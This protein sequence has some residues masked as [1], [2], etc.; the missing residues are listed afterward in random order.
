[1]NATMLR[2]PD[3]ISNN[4]MHAVVYQFDLPLRHDQLNGFRGAFAALAGREHSVFHNHDNNSQSD[5]E[6][7]HRYPLVQYRVHDGNASIYAIGEGAEAIETMEKEGAFR[8][9]KMNG[10][11][12]PLEVVRRSKE[13][14]IDLCIL[15]LQEQSRYRIYHYLPFTP[16]NYN[17]YKSHFALTT[18][19]EM[20]Q[21]LLTNHII[22]LLQGVGATYAEPLE[23]TIKDIDRVKKVKVLGQNMMAFDLVF[24]ANVNLPEGIAIGR[25]V[26]FGFG[27]TI[28][29]G[30]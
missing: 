1:M 24:S 28:G 19:V 20:L 26:A 30:G 27:F 7:L 21:G 5:R 8:H 13:R 2:S 25:K 29:I 14:N 15:R 17:T 16:E 11:A 3:G 6:Y 23:V 9:F 10:R 18:K 22:A 4:L 12:I